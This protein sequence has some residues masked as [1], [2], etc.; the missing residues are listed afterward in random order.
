MEPDY[1]QERWRAGRIGFHRG[2]ANP[3]LIEHRAT[4]DE[5]TRVLV[6]LCG[7]SADLEW[8]VVHGFQVVG[9]EL[10]DIAAQAFFS[11]R[12][13][14]P[15]RREQHP[16]VVYEHGN[17]AIWVGDFFAVTDAE[18]EPFDA[19]YDDAAL[20]ALPAELRRSY[21]A[22]QQRLIAPRAALLLI[23]LHFD[24]AGGPPFSVSPEEVH[25]LYANAT[26]IRQL[27]NADARAEVPEVVAR[28]AS[29]V[30]EQVYAVTFGQS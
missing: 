12:G 28:G 5:C 1:W 27:A 13:I 11:E 2:E 23:T 22:H 16:F 26:E 10:S 21:A 8:L 19:I 24:A 17:L 30:R 6:P 3:L 7:K 9:V 25:E 14:A 18:L 20:I 4:F 29:F 15:T